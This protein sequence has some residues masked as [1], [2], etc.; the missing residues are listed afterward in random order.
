MSEIATAKGHRSG[1][2][3]RRKKKMKNKLKM[4]N[5]KCLTELHLLVLEPQET[6]DEAAK[7]MTGDIEMIVKMALVSLPEDHTPTEE[8]IRETVGRLAQAFNA[9]EAERE[10]IV[11][12]VLARRLVRMDTGR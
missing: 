4:K 10:L 7:T 2:L 6:P 8:K 3:H 1:A 9:S 11:T 5:A 12:K